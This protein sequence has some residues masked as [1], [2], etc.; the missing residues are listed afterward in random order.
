MYSI[1]KIHQPCG[2]CV[3]WW[4]THLWPILVYPSKIHKSEMHF[5]RFLSLYLGAI[6][7]YLKRYNVY[8]IQ[9][10]I[11]SNHLAIRNDCILFA[12]SIIK[13]AVLYQPTECYVG[14]FVCLLIWWSHLCVHSLRYIRVFF[15]PACVCWKSPRTW[16]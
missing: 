13:W 8:C 4:N 10:N 12:K 16:K 2:S 14:L 7:V 1:R 3:W 9:V 11:T 6:L 15:L 5:F